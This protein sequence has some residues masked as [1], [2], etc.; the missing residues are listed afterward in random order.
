MIAH[1]R[2]V[3]RQMEGKGT[4]ITGLQLVKNKPPTGMEFVGLMLYSVRDALPRKGHLWARSKMGDAANWSI[5]GTSLAVKCIY[6]LEGMWF[7]SCPEEV[8]CF[9]HFICLLLLLQ[10]KQVSG[11]LKEHTQKK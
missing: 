3:S 2:N 6:Q 8:Q 10:K 11:F 1:N 9:S 7:N 5:P 4:G